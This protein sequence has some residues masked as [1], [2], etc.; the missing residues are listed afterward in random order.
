[1]P[2]PSL[3]AIVGRPNVGKSTLFN[4]LIGRRQAVVSSL[5]GTTRDRIVG[6]AEWRGAT[7]TLVDTGGMEFAKGDGLRGA[8]QRHI[9]R[10]LEEADGVIFVCDARE[11]LVP[12]DEMILERLRKMGKPIVLAANKADDRPIVPPEF[13]SLGLEH[14]YAVSALHG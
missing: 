11:G 14:T 7:V 13:F 10:A 3:I 8:V 12:A 6:Q 9:Q 2:I 5:R 4:R 1:M